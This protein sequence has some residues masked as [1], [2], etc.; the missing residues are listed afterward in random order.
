[1]KSFMA[2]TERSLKNNIP[3]NLGKELVTG[4]KDAYPLVTW[5]R[6]AK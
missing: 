2:W 1:M 5:L 4:F 6:Q 3:A